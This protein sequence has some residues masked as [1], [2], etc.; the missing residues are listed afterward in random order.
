MDNQTNSVENMPLI[1]IVFLMIFGTTFVGTILVIAIF[2]S[3]PTDFQYGVFRT[4]LAIA[5]AGTAVFIPGMLHL[6]MERKK[7]FVVRAGGALAV[8][9]V[10]YF[11]DPA[12]WLVMVN[13]KDHAQVQT[14]REGNNILN[15]AP[16]IIEKTP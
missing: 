11:F 5:A 13:A 10:V 7:L 4:V 12:H 1:Q 8:F 15:N 9:A 14:N 6:T 3:Q 2:I 16:V